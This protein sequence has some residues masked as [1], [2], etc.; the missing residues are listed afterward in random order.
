MT[1]TDTPATKIGTDAPCEMC[2]RNTAKID[3][4]I[5]SGLG[6]FKGLL[7][8]EMSVCGTCYGSMLPA[9]KNR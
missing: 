2:L 8:T 1:S 6:E 7:T 9:I 4:L 5:P 3:I